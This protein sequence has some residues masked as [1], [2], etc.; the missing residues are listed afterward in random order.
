MAQGLRAEHLR[1]AKEA[2]RL[3]PPRGVSE[4]GADHW[5][6]A[7]SRVVQRS[8][9]KQ[10]EDADARR[11]TRETYSGLEKINFPCKGSGR[12][13]KKSLI[14]SLEGTKRGRPSLKKKRKRERWAKN[15]HVPNRRDDNLSRWGKQAHARHPKRQAKRSL[16]KEYEARAHSP[17]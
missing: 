15:L 9:A 2:D 13:P 4:D 6:R 10:G 5:T 3:H 11:R 7:T 8:R 17:P 16:D 12:P 1:I 14:T